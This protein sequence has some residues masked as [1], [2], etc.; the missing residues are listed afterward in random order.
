MSANNPCF[1]RSGR[2]IIIVIIILAECLT[3]RSMASENE[4]SLTFIDVNAGKVYAQVGT[5]HFAAIDT[6][7]GLVVWS[8]QDKH[9]QLFTKAVFS[10][11]A[12]FVA[13]TRTNSTSELIRLDLATGKVIWR[14]PVE[15]LGGNASPV[16]CADEVLEPDYWHKTVS[17]FNAL[18]GKK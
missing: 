14:M 15:G 6:E 11:D 7:T 12:V 4:D 13:A 16:L 2:L 9:L 10:S 8:F 17:A 1:L 5:G 3:G 18:T